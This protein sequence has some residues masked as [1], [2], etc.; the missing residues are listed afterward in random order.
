MKKD[1]GKS[2]VVAPLPV[3]IIAT[4][5]E[6]GVPDAMNA[7]WGGQC[8]HQHVALNLA[9][10]HKTT[11]NLRLK[12]AFTVSIA[13]KG[14]L[15]LSDYFGLVSGRKADKMTNAH[16]HITPSRFV[17]APVIEEYPLVLECK[18]VSMEE[19]FGEVRVV[20]EVLNAQ[21]D[22]SVLNDVG[23]VDLDKLQPLS[24]DSVARAY[25]VLGGIV[26]T[27]FKDGTQLIENK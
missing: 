23:K 13:N 19:S 4:Y 25:R 1:L 14:N 5:D 21:A 16:V 15:V 24:F 7:A 3:L 2:T 10:G 27:A 12:K 22:E 8:T 17:D 18:V 26:G 6:N 9:K 11:E 20:G